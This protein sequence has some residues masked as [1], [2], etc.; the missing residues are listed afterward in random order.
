[1]HG[2]LPFQNG[3]YRYLQ[4]PSLAKLVRM[5]AVWSQPAC[6]ATQYANQRWF[7][8]DEKSKNEKT[9]HV[10][11]STFCDLN[12]FDNSNDL[13]QKDD[14]L[15][16]VIDLGCTSCYWSRSA[17]AHLHRTAGICKFSFKMF[18][19]KFAIRSVGRYSSR[20]PGFQTSNPHPSA[21]WELLTRWPKKLNSLKSQPHFQKMSTSSDL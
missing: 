16:L 3:F 2:L 18:Q 1:M 7:A 17:W 10:M 15:L 4:G 19:S 8:P 12:S 11:C 20:T 9:C 21:E 13:L 14:L 5:H 6:V